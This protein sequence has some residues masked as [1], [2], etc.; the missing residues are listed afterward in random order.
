M[1]N[2]RRDTIWEEGGDLDPEQVQQSREEKMSYMVKTLGIFDLGSWEEAT[3][4]AGKASAT[5][6][7]IDR[8]KKNDD[9]RRR[10]RRREQRLHTLQGSARRD[11]N[12]ATKCKLCSPT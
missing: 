6:K 10:W 11:E 2:R 1:E 3:L 5:T 4:K 9:G 7:W 8:M 12:R